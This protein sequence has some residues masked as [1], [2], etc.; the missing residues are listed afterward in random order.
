MAETLRPWLRRLTF[1]LSTVLGIAPRG[2]FI[3]Y[4]YA[5]AI[6]RPVRYGAVEALFERHGG[7]FAR[8]I[9]E[10]DGL[11]E[12]LLA[13]GKEPPPA[14]RWT[15]DWFSRLDGAIAYAMVRRLR[16][17]RL[18]E[19]GSGHS[20]RF[21]AR[22]VADGRTG[23]MITTVDPA[24]RAD[25]GGLGVTTMRSTLQQT[26][27][28]PFAELAA[29]DI[30]SIDSSHILMPG[31]DVELLMTNVLPRLA[32][33]VVV[34]VHDIFLPDDYPA[35]W[36]WRGYNEQSAVVQLILGGGW[37][38]LWSSRY[39]LTRMAEAISASVLGRLPLPKGAFESSL[40]LER[41]PH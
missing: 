7:S 34:H 1:G 20:T 25:L 32:A 22:A 41:R 36:T 8:M 18:V 14:P 40:W 2:F 11:A 17:A 13:I 23:T 38:P 35:E 30:V 39:V 24:P 26:G 37:Q 16:P 12:D 28:A 21:F 31:S 9:A 19:V 10:A 29:G 4:R 27:P 15:Q 5:A 6:R 33:G 3:P